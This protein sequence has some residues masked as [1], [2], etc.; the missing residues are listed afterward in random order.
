MLRSGVGNA[1]YVLV[2]IAL[3]FALPTG[4]HAQLEPFQRDIELVYIFEGDRTEFVFVIGQAGFKSVDSLKAHLA[5]WP[6]GSELRWAPGCKRMGG[7]PILSS[8]E[9]MEAFRK[10]LGEH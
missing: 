7:E 5:T 2:G 1:L 9:E 10:F 3:F 6:R 8:D 4:A